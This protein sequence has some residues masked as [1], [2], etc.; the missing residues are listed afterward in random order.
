[1]SSEFGSLWLKTEPD[2][3]GLF[4][5]FNIWDF[6]SNAVFTFNIFVK[7]IRLIKY[8][9]PFLPALIVAFQYF[10]PLISITNP[11]PAVTGED[12]VYALQ[13]GAY[14]YTLKFLSS[15]NLER[16]FDFFH[17]CYKLLENI[18][19]FVHKHFLSHLFEFVIKSFK[20]IAAE[21][22]DYLSILID[23]FVEHFQN[24]N[25]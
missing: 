2:Y 18:A 14:T 10:G 19:V 17:S 24:G 21:L 25:L 9:A 7:I 13:I 5:V 4:D 11:Q 20:N 3:K 23:V 8:I 6:W 1:M 15:K 16:I 12:S 22:W